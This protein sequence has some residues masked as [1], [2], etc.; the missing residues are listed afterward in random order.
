MNNDDNKEENNNFDIEN[1]KR[2]LLAYQLKEKQIQL[3]P[4]NNDN[5]STG[6]VGDNGDNLKTLGNHNN[7]ESLKKSSADILVELALENS[8]LFKGEHGIPHALVKINN[9]HDVLSIKSSKFECYLSKLYYENKDKKIPNVEAIN[10]AKRMLAAQ[11]FFAGP[12]IPLYLR[13]SW[14]NS[15]TKDAISYDLTDDNKRCI[16]I[17][18]GNGWKIVDNQIEV[19]FKRHGHETSQIEPSHYYDSN[20]LDGF[21][22]SLN[23]TNDNQKLLVKI[24]VISLLIP[25]IA[26]PNLLPYGEKGSAKSTLQKKIKML[27]DPSSL[28]LL[29][30][31]NN[32][33]QFVQQL[34][35]HFL[36][37]YDNV[38]YVPPW[39]SDETCR[40]ITGGA[41]SK[42]ELFT[43]DED[44]SYRYK[45]RMSLVVL[46][47]YLQKKMH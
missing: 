10:N 5:G 22:D 3:E 34:S 42:R 6:A 29:S 38:R 26:I 37:F 2:Q 27:I 24:W 33:T 47:S 39:L 32:K 46:M 44:I 17:I 20:I 45:K 1:I 12:T 18:K 7:Y 40:A 36:C 43:D 41:F 28:D 13:V 25:D 15:E 11:A 9:H 14:S 21:V 4:N 8:T 35:H 30:F 31:Y 23:I 16:K 19:L